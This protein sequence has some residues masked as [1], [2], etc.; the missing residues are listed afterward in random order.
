M[1]TEAWRNRIVGAADVAP[2]QLVANPANW[3]THPGPQRDALRGSL[4]EVGWVQQV[5]V[6]QRTGFVVDG[7]ARVEEAL[8]RGEPTVPVLYVDLDP[9]EEAL[10]LATLDP[11][12]AMAT[13]DDARLQELLSGLV[14]DDAGLLALLADLAPLKPTV[15]LT[16]PDDIPP[17]GDDSGIKAGDL[18]ALGDHRLMCGDSTV[19]A[20]HARLMGGA[21]AT[22]LATDP[23]YGVDYASVVGGRKNQK[24]G[25]WR[26]IAG[27]ELRDEPLFELVRDALALSDAKTLFLWHAAKR[28]PIFMRALEETGFELAQQIIWVKN[29]L[30]FGGSDY[31]WRHE[32]CFYAR[33]KGSWCDDDRTQTTVWEFSKEHEPVHPT[34]KPV[35]LF[36]IP[37]RRH[38]RS[39]D[40]CYEP[41]SGSGS[42][43]IAAEQLGRRCYAMEIDPRY[44]AVAIKRWED[45]TGRTSE[46]L[47]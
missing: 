29:A 24:A 47:P 4:T 18:F 30:V 2:D 9:A 21:K 34:Q 10:V 36:A 42:Q 7:H 20:D 12:G 40:V 39:G 43:L 33:R 5:M 45:F 16:D 28:S 11:I 8:T 1:V 44:V 22:L 38:T 14:V 31:Q 32:P 19:A 35:E 26:D 27:D 23:P 6:N 37:M 15:G 17:L 41:F 46:R 13:R 25:G 3:R